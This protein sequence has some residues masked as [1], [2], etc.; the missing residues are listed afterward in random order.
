MSLTNSS[1]GEIAKSASIASRL[2]ATLSGAERD[3]A[4][5]A[6]HEAIAKSRNDILA[7]NSRDVAAAERAVEAGVLNQSVLKRLDLSRPGKFEDMLQGILSVRDLQDPG[8]N[9]TKLLRDLSLAM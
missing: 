7:A 5:T 3:D 1:P 9:S 4:L 8:I 6:L 2:L